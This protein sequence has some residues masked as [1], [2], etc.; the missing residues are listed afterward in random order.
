[1]WGI[2][3][4]MF[5]GVSSVLPVMEASTMKDHFPVLLGSALATLLVVDIYF[6]E[7][8]YYNFGESLKESIVI[9]QMPQDNWWII[10]GKIL[11]CINIIFSYPLII[12]IIYQIIESNLFKKMKYSLLRTWLKNLSRTTIVVIGLFVAYYFYYSI[13]KI[14]S[15]YGVVF[16]NF[17]VLI[18]PSLVHYKLIADTKCSKLIDILIIIYS[19]SMAIILGVLIIMRWD[20]N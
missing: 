13:H 20:Y 10:I 19:A 14:L 11:F 16:G 4:Y 2:S 8:C 17:V 15:F 7:L 18:T 6:S 1:M 5:E 12:P 9:L 3:F